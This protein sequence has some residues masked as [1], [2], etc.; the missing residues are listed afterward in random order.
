MRW[1]FR[2]TSGRQSPLPQ[3]AGCT[4]PFVSSAPPGESTS[5]RVVIGARSYREARSGEPVRYPSRAT[6]RACRISRS[7]S[8]PRPRSRRRRRPRRA[9]AAA[10]EQVPCA[11]DVGAR[12]RG[13]CDSS[14]PASEAFRLPVTGSSRVHAVDSGRT[15]APRRPRAG[16]PGGARRRRHPARRRRDGGRAR[17]RASASS[18]ATQPGPLSTQWLSRISPASIRSIAA[19]RVDQL[20]LDR[21][22]AHERRVP[23]TRS[24]RSVRRI[25]IRPG[26]ALLHDHIVRAG[27]R[28]PC[29]ARR[30]RCRASGDRRTA[31]RAPA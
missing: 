1:P 27:G 10:S 21:P 3:R 11:A 18:T 26:G 19:I 13:R 30:G 25:G 17:P 23:R 31:A 8:R 15:R 22:R 5:V 2:P 6:A 16:R 28:P 12:S 29:S 24:P 20:G 7:A 4:S 9:R 14:Q